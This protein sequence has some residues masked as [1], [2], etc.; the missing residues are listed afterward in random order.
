M[1]QDSRSVPGG[2]PSKYTDQPLGKHP[3]QITKR[4]A[5][6]LGKAGLQRSVS[7]AGLD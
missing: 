4:P 1:T 5:Q 2:S 3:L 7:R 6:P